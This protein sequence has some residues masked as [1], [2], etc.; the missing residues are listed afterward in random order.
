MRVGD[1]PQRHKKVNLGDYFHQVIVP[2]YIP[3]LENYYEAS[4]E[5]FQLSMQS[6]IKTSHSKTFIS[7][8]SN[9]SCDEVNI[10]ISELYLQ[11]KIHEFTITKAIGKLNSILKGLSGITLPLVTITDA[12]VLFLNKW[13]EAT[14]DVF[15]HFPKAGVV[16]PVPNPSASFYETSNIFRQNL[17]SN[18]IQFTTIKNKAAVLNF[19]KSIGQKDLIIKNHPEKYL[20]VSKNTKFKAVIGCGHFVTTYKT[21]LFDYNFSRST[22]FL[23]GGQSENDLLDKK[24]FELDLW[25]LATLDNYAYHL[26]NTV[27]EWVPAVFNNLTEEKNNFIAPKHLEVIQLGFYNKIYSKIFNKIVG[28]YKLRNLLLKTISQK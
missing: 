19:A 24:P 4:F 27:S 1:N 16:G 21:H 17:F 20:T 11:K 10:Y 28:S 8:I 12:D 6:L 14:Y 26:G 23:L 2:V 13:Q 3:N 15:E 18:H 5:V 22:E 25:R 7:V 9:G